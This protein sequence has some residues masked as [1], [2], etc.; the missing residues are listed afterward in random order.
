M[1]KVAT[2]ERSAPNVGAA[3]ER[4]VGTSWR[5]SKNSNAKHVGTAATKRPCR[6]FTEKHATR[7]NA[8]RGSPR[9]VVTRC[10]PSEVALR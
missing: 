8:R 10:V 6:I 9:L 4:F 5:D 7:W 3:I 1:R 2:T